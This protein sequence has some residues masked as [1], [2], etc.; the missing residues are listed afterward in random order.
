MGLARTP[1]F[2]PRFI[3]PGGCG[4]LSSPPEDAEL[5]NSGFFGPG[6]P[7]WPF[8]PGP[9][10]VLCNERGE[11]R[12]FES[13]DSGCDRSARRRRVGWCARFVKPCRGGDRKP[14]GSNVSFTR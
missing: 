2:T 3:A 5:A 7:E 12:W 13:R 8:S 14:R 9:L 6:R 10:I 1:R 11:S 4:A